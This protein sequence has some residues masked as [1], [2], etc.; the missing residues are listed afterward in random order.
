MLTGQ[1]YI[2]PQIARYTQGSGDFR[3]SFVSLDRTTTPDSILAG[4]Y[5]ESGTAGRIARWDIDYT[6]RNLSTGKSTEMW[7]IGEVSIQGAISVNGKYYF[8][9]SRALSKGKMFKW[10]GTG[11]TE[12]VDLGNIFPVGP[13]DLSYMK[14]TGELWSC[15]EHPT[16]RKLWAV[17]ASAL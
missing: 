12:L 10:A 9:R 13:E 7:R 17:K 16:T 8:T 5:Q 1:R 11:T 3:F 6:T 2:I 4:E 14:S 15:G